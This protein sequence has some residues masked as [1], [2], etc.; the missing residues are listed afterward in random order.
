MT[1]KYNYSLSY[2]I[3]TAIPSFADL[4]DAVGTTPIRKAFTFTS[5]AVA[6][7]SVAALVQPTS[8]MRVSE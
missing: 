5:A 4:A 6:Y 3:I 1:I 2:K 7:T 8:A